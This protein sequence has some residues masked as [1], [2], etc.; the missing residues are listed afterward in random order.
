MA[1]KADQKPG[2]IV[3]LDEFP[4]LVGGNSGLPSII[5]KF[6]DSGVVQPGALKIVLCG[7]L[8]AQME[9]CSPNE[10]RSSVGRPLRARS[11]RCLSERLPSSCPFGSIALFSVL[12]GVPYYLNMCDPSLSLAD[13]IMQ[14]FLASSAPLQEEPDFLLRSELNDAGAMQALRPRSPTVPLTF[15]DRRARARVH[16]SDR[17]LALHRSP[18]ADAYRHARTLPRRRRSFAEHPILASGPAFQLL[19]PLRAANLGAV[20]R[21]FGDDIWMRAIKPHFNGYMGPVF[22]AVSREH[23]P[24]HAQERF[25]VP[26]RECQSALSEV[27]S[28]S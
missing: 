27:A 17:S 21:G 20:G 8:I 4:Y 22:E 5:Q 13:N 19:V 18:A 26:A 14:L 12:G 9:N 1:E 16:R 15:G 2:L 7:S 28:A 6:W 3:A 24:D 23:L 11:C 25:D 10:I